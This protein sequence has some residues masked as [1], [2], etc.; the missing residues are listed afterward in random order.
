MLPCL[1]SVLLTFQIQSVLKFEKKSVTKRL[2]QGCT[3]TIHVSKTAVFQEK[4]KVLGTIYDS[5][6]HSN[7]SVNKVRL[8][9]SVIGIYIIFMLFFTVLNTS[10]MS[11]MQ[12]QKNEIHIFQIYALIRILGQNSTC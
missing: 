4:N 6:I 9:I 12:H 8:R 2:I 10:E 1:V 11:C 5:R 7:P 3:N